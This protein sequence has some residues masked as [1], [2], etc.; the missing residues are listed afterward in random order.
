MSGAFPVSD[1]LLASI[2][3]PSTARAEDIAGFLN[4]GIATKPTDTT[5]VGK[6][7][8]NNS[9]FHRR[10]PGHLRRL[11]ARRA[12]SEEQRAK[13]H[14]RR[15]C[16]GSDGRLPPEIRSAFSEGQRAVLNVIGKQ[17]EKNGTCKLCID[18]IAAIAGVCRR[19]V[20][21]AIRRAQQKRFISVQERQRSG[22]RNDTNLVEVICDRW[23][24]WLDFPRKRK[25]GG[26][27]NVHAKK[28]SKHF[29]H[30]REKDHSEKH[31]LSAIEPVQTSE[32]QR[33]RGRETSAPDQ[34]QRSVARKSNENLPAVVDR[35]IDPPT[36]DIF[37]PWLRPRDLR[38][39]V[40]S[41]RSDSPFYVRP[42]IDLTVN[43]TDPTNGEEPCGGA[44]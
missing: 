33:K 15:R 21:Y 29:N 36:E 34:S 26:C 41:K 32:G 39:I 22:Q 9:T 35:I 14:A 19:L 20:Q 44:S 3:R 16:I 27:T 31:D 18:A 5:L 7:V 6:P 8:F 38:R 40:N 37:E 11:P 1:R 4:G 12:L 25:G 43:A 10:I 2:S 23:L 42:E 17:V 24:D 13:A 30:C 28:K